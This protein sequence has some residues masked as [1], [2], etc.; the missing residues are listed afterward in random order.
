MADVNLMPHPAAGA[1]T[2]EGWNETPY[3]GLEGTLAPAADLLSKGYPRD[4]G[5]QVTQNANGN[6]YSATPQVTVTAGETYTFSCHV[7]IP[8]FATAQTVTTFIDWLDSSGAFLSSS[9]GSVALEPTVV[10]QAAVTGTA[11]AGAASGYFAFN[12]M[13]DQTYL[14]AAMAYPGT[15]VD[16]YRDGESAGW[17]WDG[18]RYLS[19][20][21]LDDGGGDPGEGGQATLVGT[22]SDLGS[23]GYDPT[24]TVPGVSGGDTLVAIGTDSY[25]GTA[26]AITSTGGETWQPLGNPLGDA[27]GE[28]N[29]RMSAWTA[30][31]AAGGSDTVTLSAVDMAT[32]TVL[33]LRDATGVVDV[34][35]TEVPRNAGPTA[36]QALG[37]VDVPSGGGLLIGAWAGIAFP[38]DPE[39]ISWAAPASMVEQ[40]QPRVN[41]FNAVL[42][43]TEATTAGGSVTR[44]ATATPAPAAG[45]AGKLLVVTGTGGGE[46]L[47]DTAAERYGWGTPLPSSDEFDYTGPPDPARW[48]VYDSAG[49]DGNGTRDPAQ[50]TVQDGYLRI[51]GNVTGDTGGM[52]H[53]LDQRYGR[54]ELRARWDAVTPGSAGEAYHA[55]LIVWPNG[56]L[57]EPHWPQYGE[58]DFVEIVDVEQD[59]LEAYLHY[60]H[61]GDVPV[62]QEIVNADP[63]TFDFSQWHNYAF[64]WIDGR[65]RGFVDG[66]QWFDLDGTQV[67]SSGDRLDGMPSGHLAIQL[68]NFTGESGLQPAYLDV[69][70]A[71]VYPA[72]GSAEVGYTTASSALTTDVEATAVKHGQAQGAA[73]LELSADATAAKQTAVAASSGL[74]LG[75]RVDTARPV[76][77]TASSRLE[78]GGDAATST[79]REQAGR[80]PLGLSGAATT[81]KA[82]RADAAAE[83]ELD[84]RAET[85][86]TAAV[87]GRSPLELGSDAVSTRTSR[88]VPASALELDGRAVVDR[89]GKARAVAG[90]EL[91]ARAVG[92]KVTGTEV[93]APL[94]L[95]AVA[96]TSEQQLARARSALPLDAVA[97]TDRASAVRATAA[98]GLGSRVRSTRAS[99]V[100]AESGL[101]LAQ[102]AVTARTSTVRGEA[103]LVLGARADVAQVLVVTAGSALP[104]AGE[105][106]TA[107][108]GVVAA[109]GA[110][111][112]DARTE[113]DRIS[114]VRVRAQ[115]PLAGTTALERIASVDAVAP[116]LL[117]SAALSGSGIQVAAESELP[118][119][120]RAVAVKAAR[121]TPA[122]P[123]LLDT[124]VLSDRISLTEATP[125]LL[126]DGRT[127]VSG[128]RAVVV[129]APLLL[130]AIA[131][132][133]L[134][135]VTF[136]P[137][138][139]RPQLEQLVHLGGPELELLVV[140]GA[141]RTY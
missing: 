3:P 46:P 136:P 128:L 69:E 57:P 42:V 82:G 123:V 80:S 15:T 53:M 79:M 84:G 97:R 31:V 105:V 34:V 54:W 5:V 6:S 27:G 17:V 106:A 96:L 73:E 50:V 86:R 103:P 10:A 43:A 7:A 28:A 90:L 32:L 75:S 72:D 89:V 60:P 127:E 21:R 131:L 112:L 14:T 98:L 70:W 12:T 114:T 67:S 24:V 13:P 68:D 35:D 121:T 92:S 102:T 20:S 63:R 19:T 94:M 137:V 141:P 74:P 118:M 62:E 87:A 59:R 56:S 58:Y 132:A 52:A 109:A 41:N 55:V 81:S 49:H 83:L 2:T 40:A 110:L 78:L 11:P 111:P 48:A 61:P 36:D 8:P 120:G 95:G 115:L 133:E 64:E 23:G 134:P 47:P 26:P 135:P 44:T 119:G 85:S 76:S 30:D 139:G 39:F 18:T 93:A 129:R 1:G 140:V 101:W 25:T 138:L 71:R 91:D 33:H 45:F 16:P 37:P 4:T 107:K 38:P 88:A 99:T 125:A 116:L 65:L 100:A 130:D 51:A 113:S 126:L 122:A 9:S 29:Q 77:V 108:R 124:R 117:D 66:A 104:L 22:Y